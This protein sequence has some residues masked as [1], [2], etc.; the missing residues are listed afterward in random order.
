MQRTVEESE[1]PSDGESRTPLR[2]LEANTPRRRPL[3][4][5]TTLGINVHSLQHIITGSHLIY[6]KEVHI[7]PAG[8]SQATARLV[9]SDRRKAPP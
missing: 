3:P 1:A 4:T 2:L 8:R 9:Q 7:V 5:S 6:H